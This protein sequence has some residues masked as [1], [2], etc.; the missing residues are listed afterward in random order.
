MD[1]G[2]RAYLLDLCDAAIGERGARDHIFDWLLDEA[3]E[4]PRA[5]DAWW[6]ARRLAVLLEA[7]PTPD[8]QRRLKVLAAYEIETVLLRLDSFERD[9]AG[10]LRRL[11]EHDERHVRSELLDPGSRFSQRLWFGPEIVGVNEAYHDDP[12]DLD[13]LDD[14]W[15]V[16]EDEA[17]FDALDEA[18]EPVAPALDPGWRG[19]AMARAALG[20]AVLA[21]RAF[22]VAVAGHGRTDVETQVLV[23]IALV[24]PGRPTD[25]GESDAGLRSALALDAW[26]V[27][28]ALEGLARRG[29]VEADRGEPADPPTWSATDAGAEA[30]EAWVGRLG[31]VFAGWPPD[32]PGVDDAIG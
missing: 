18:E 32:R 24:P 11:A 5:V 25:E 15:D 12:A 17:H 19:G 23:W 13:D 2:D 27:R 16:A 3:G 14:D 28:E 31:S 21:R 22:A 6:P 30:V 29:L 4:A 26:E 7:E 8:L 1:P 10:A 9:G 20:A